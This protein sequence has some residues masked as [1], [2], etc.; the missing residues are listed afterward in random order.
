M[1]HDPFATPNH[2][3]KVIPVE[4]QAHGGSGHSGL[5]LTLGE[6]LA[7]IMQIDVS[8][9]LDGNKNFMVTISG[10]RPAISARLC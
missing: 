10:L 9:S 4:G 8:L 1:S 2:D 5:G 3:T 6:A 7:R